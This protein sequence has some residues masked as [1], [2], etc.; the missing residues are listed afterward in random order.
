VIPDAKRAPEEGGKVDQSPGDSHEAQA[1]KLLQDND[2]EGK[3]RI[4]L[5]KY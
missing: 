2:K 5:P 1:K 4:D 3:M